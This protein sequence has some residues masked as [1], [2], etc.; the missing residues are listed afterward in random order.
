MEIKVDETDQVVEKF[1]DAYNKF[2]DYI[3]YVETIP[4]GKRTMKQKELIAKFGN[5]KEKRHNLM[6]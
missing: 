5:K 6:Q 4:E 3:K 1:R 2:L